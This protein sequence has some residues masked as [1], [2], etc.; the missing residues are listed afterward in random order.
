MHA[1]SPPCPPTGHA[2]KR[3]AVDPD[4]SEIGRLLDRLD[5]VFRRLL[6]VA[7]RLFVVGNYERIGLLREA[8]QDF[9]S[10]LSGQHDLTLSVERYTEDR[11]SS[12]TSEHDVL[13]DPAMCRW[14]DVIR[15]ELGCALPGCP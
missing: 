15:G 8:R 7:G 12:L 9:A 11:R 5:P 14:S 4:L 10:C 13:A 2:P 6:A 1:P 3:G